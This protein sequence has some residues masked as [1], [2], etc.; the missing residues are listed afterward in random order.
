MKVTPKPHIKFHF[1]INS[2]K[3]AESLICVVVDTLVVLKLRL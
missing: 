2:K 3:M 1:Q